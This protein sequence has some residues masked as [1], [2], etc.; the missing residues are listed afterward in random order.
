MKRSVTY[1]KIKPEGSILL[2][3]I[4]LYILA[5]ADVFS[6]TVDPVQVMGGSRLDFIHLRNHNDTGYYLFHGEADLAVSLS[7]EGLGLY[8]G[9]ELF[10]QGMGVF[11]QKASADYAGDLQVFSNIES[12][13]R[14]FLYQLWYRQAIGKFVIRF[15]Q[16]DMNSD[17][18]VSS[19]ASPMINSSFGVIPTISLNMPV[20]IFAYL[21]PGISV[22]YLHSSRWTF[23]TAFFDGYPGDYE[24]NRHNLRWRLGDSEGWFNITEAHYKTRSNLMPGKY[25]LGAFYHSRGSKDPANP[26]DPGKGSL[27]LFVMGDQ[28]VIAEKNTIRNGLN[29]F[30]QLS[31]CFGDVSFIRAYGSLGLIY[32]G[33]LPRMNE[34]ELTVALATIRIDERVTELNPLMLDHETVLEVTYKKYITPGII[35]QPD[36]QYVINP[37]ATAEVDKDLSVLLLRA[38]F[39]F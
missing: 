16:L 33:L 36:F 4:I 11:G 26:D 6:Q 12:D 15:G 14:L 22:K 5:S 24:T 20:S 21:A 34:D 27:G 19:W 37:G 13:T 18:S 38:S 31:Y 30:F 10:I 2:P 29:M 7:S 32:R 17:Y 3:G 25:K 28:Q 9:G 8:K 35:I 23:Q 1:K 39:S